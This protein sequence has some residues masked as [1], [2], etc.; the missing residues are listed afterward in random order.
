M[1]WSKLRQTFA[2]W[3]QH[4]APRLAAALAFYTIL[5][6]APLVILVIAILASVFGHSAAQNQ[7][8]GEVESMIGKQGSEAVKAMIEHGQ[9]PAPGAVAS[10]AGV[11]TLFFG[12]GVF[13]ELRSALNEIWDL[14]PK[15]K[16]GCGAQS[17]NVSFLSAW[18]WLSH[19]CC[20]SRC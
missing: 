12:P 19:S 2:K 16:V 17:N 13:G 14:K 5:S 4:E 3:N 6:L 10:V 18:R 11:I 8:L 20:W 15:T 1:I 7:L 9:K